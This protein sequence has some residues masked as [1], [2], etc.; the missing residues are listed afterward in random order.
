[1]VFT[2]SNADSRSKRAQS[3]RLSSELTYSSHLVP[4]YGGLWE[5]LVHSIFRDPSPFQPWLHWILGQPYSF[6]HI[7]NWRIIALQC[8]AGFCHPTMRIRSSFCVYLL[9]SLPHPNLQVVTEHQAG[10]HVSCS[11]FLLAICFTHTMV[12]TCQCYCLSSHHPLLFALW[13]TATLNCLS[14]GMIHISSIHIYSRRSSPS[15]PPSQCSVA[16]HSTSPACKSSRWEL[17]KTQTHARVS[18]HAGQLTCLTRTVTCV[19]PLQAVVYM[20]VRACVGHR[21]T[22]SLFQA[23][24]VQKQL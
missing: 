6:F 7:F 18:S 24:G 20:T 23:Q 16:H 22:E 15:V 3:Q 8:C 10:P 14:L 12:C 5:A 2:V 21:S 4:V 13:D 1:M 11:S 9:P 19:R 17:S